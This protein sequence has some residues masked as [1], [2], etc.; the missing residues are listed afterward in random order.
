MKKFRGKGWNR[1]EVVAV[2]TSE[3]MAC[4]NLALLEDQFAKYRG[5]T[6]FGPEQ[7]YEVCQDF[8]DIDF[9]ILVLISLNDRNQLLGIYVVAHG[10]ENLVPSPPADELFEPAHKSAGTL[11]IL[12]H[13]HPD[14]NFSASERDV[15]FAKWARRKASSRGL[16]LLDSLSVS[17]EGYTSLVEQGELPQSPNW[18]KDGG[19]ISSRTLDELEA[20]FGKIEA[21]LLP[22]SRPTE[23]NGGPQGGV[24]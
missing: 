1:S 21:D 7:A 14:G 3:S 24:E 22:N 20:L 12:V 9:E 18:G 17:V 19:G 13:N 8:T 2:Q 23:F 6:I 4:A 5:I 15:E 16:V 11:T 10:D